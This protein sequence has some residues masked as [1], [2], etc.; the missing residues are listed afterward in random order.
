VYW[1]C[2]GTGTVNGL[3][4]DPVQGSGAE[5]HCQKSFAPE[6]TFES[7][8]FLA[9][10]AKSRIVLGMAENQDDPLALDG[11]LEIPGRDLVVW[12]VRP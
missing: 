10:K 4:A 7:A 3:G 6:R 1:Y 5:F 11:H 2:P 9:R 12:F 8:G